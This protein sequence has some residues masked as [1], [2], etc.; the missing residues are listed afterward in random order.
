MTNQQGTISAEEIKAALEKHFG[1]LM[2]NLIC[3]N[4]ALEK[5]I[6]VLLTSNDAL[7]ERI[8]ILESELAIHRPPPSSLSE[9]AQAIAEGARGVIRGE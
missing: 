1:T 3:Q 4:F 8:Q 6:N 9:E 7:H 5:R 2:S